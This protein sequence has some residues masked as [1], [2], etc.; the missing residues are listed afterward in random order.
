MG[1]QQVSTLVP[2]PELCGYFHDCLGSIFSTRKGG[3][4]RL[5]PIPHGGKTKKTYYRV[6]VAGKLRFIHRLVASCWY[7][8]Q[9]PSHLHVNH[10]DGNTE[11][12]TQNNL[13]IVTHYENSQHA[14]KHGLYCKG[15]AWHAARNR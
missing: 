4:K 3:L 1:N 14:K 5:K 8:S 10:I 2:I 12:N 7:G 11:N 6:K 9:I 15:S 13:E